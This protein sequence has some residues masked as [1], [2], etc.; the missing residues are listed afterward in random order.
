MSA[1]KAYKF[2]PNN[3]QPPPLPSLVDGELENEVDCITSTRKEGKSRSTCSWC[4]GLDIMKQRGRTC[5]T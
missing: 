4:T 1:L 3:Y 5:K 2:S